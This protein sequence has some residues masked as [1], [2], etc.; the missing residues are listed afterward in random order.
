MSDSAKEAWKVGAMVVFGLFMLWVVF[1]G[2][3]E[4]QSDRNAVNIDCTDPGMAAGSPYCNG[5]FESGDGTENS[6]YQNAVR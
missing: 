1:G 4:D 3:F 5:G 2:I 6:Y